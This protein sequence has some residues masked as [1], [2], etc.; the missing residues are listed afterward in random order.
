MKTCDIIVPIYNAPEYVKLCIYTIFKNT[1]ESTIGKVYLMNDNSNDFT[2]NMLQN[3]QEKYKEKIVLVTNEENLGFV[4]NVNKGL[5]LSKAPYKL[6]LNTDCF[7]GHHTIEKMINHIEKNPKIGLICPIS[8]NAANLTL[9]MY[10]GF[11]YMMMDKLLEKK[12]KGLCFDACTVVGNC[13]M[14]TRDCIEKTGYLD[15]IFGMGYC[16]ETD[17]QFKAMEQGFEAKVAIDTYVFHKAEMSFSTTN[18][19]REIRF[20]NNSKI[21]WSRWKQQYDQLMET[22]KK[23][24]PIEYIKKHITKEDKKI[25]YDAMFL[26]PFASKT[27]GGVRV[28]VDLINYLSINNQ[29]IGMLNLYPCEYSEILIFEPARVKDIENIET[30]I[31]VGTVYE[32]MF[33]TKKLA[34]KY[35]AK[36]VYFS[37]GYEFVFLNGLR[38]GEVDVSFKMADYV[39]TISNYL[40]QEYK[41][42][43]NIDSHLIINGIDTYLTKTKTQLRERKSIDMV[44]RNEPRKADY[45]ILDLIKH[46]TVM[47]N[48]IDIHLI[49]LNKDMVLGVNNNPSIQIH[50]YYGPLTRPQI[51][52]I[53]KQ[54]D[55]FVDT[56]ISEG[57][58]LM[59]LEAMA[60]GVVP[61][62]SDSFGIRD[63]A[64]QNENA[65]I[66]D[67]VN[68]VYA[69]INAIKQLLEN[70]NQLETM[71]QKAYETVEKFDFDKVVEKY[72]QTFQNFASGEITPIK[73]TITSEELTLLSN[74]V[75]SNQKLHQI[76]K[77]SNYAEEG[78]LVKPRR[79]TRIK[80]LIK[81]FIKANVFLTKE[82]IKAII[83]K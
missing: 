54:V 2:K 19:S 6:L 60:F 44:L 39:L 46:I 57:F 75:I 25:R 23:N 22:Y 49:I 55:I 45:L 79:L 33:L 4:K 62:I 26:L 82:F 10:P 27:S 67:K 83:N 41:N 28:I 47:M 12:F 53:L 16:E 14:I 17:Y 71:Q 70:P 9:P 15:E 68:D 65:I 24:D 32:S 81:E 58:G 30:K 50:K 73:Q 56:S 34:E 77:E 38:Y 72:I 31:M 8:S 5:R 3:L 51:Y 80:R 78:V 29:N 18:T 76:I 61:V 43:Y 69:Y 37:Q 1:D 40:K 21:F 59:P 52:E 11:S 48:N 74:Y 20:Q 63:F 13:L 66:I 36:T 64:K 42:L 35:N 7:L